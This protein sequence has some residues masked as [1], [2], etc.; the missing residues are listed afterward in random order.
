MGKHIFEHVLSN[1]TGLLKHKTRI[2]VTNAIYVLPEV[3]QIILLKDGTI[4]NVGSFQ[5]LMDNCEDFSE[6]VQ[7]FS[8]TVVEDEVLVHDFFEEQEKPLGLSRQFS[9]TSQSSSSS[10]DRTYS[11]FSTR[12]KRI[13]SSEISKSRLDLSK[14]IHTEIAET[15]NVSSSVYCKFIKSL[16]PCWAIIIVIN[17]MSVIGFDAGLN[18]WLAEWTDDLEQDNNKNRFYLLVYGMIG[19]IKMFFVCFGWISIIS[20]VVNASTTLHTQLIDRIAHAPMYFFNVTP[21]GRIINRFSKD[22]DVID[23]LQ[24]FIRYARFFLINFQMKI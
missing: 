8:E 17:Y 15:G 4:I 24:Y 21:L 1:Q 11:T 12:R 2:L 19:I 7:N 20:G 13:S 18:F 6:L 23:N 14:L 10:R 3:D 9:R 22:I 5:F 16:T